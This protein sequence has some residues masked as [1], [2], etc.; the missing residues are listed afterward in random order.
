MVQTANIFIIIKWCKQLILIK[1]PKTIFSYAL[2]NR[3][4]NKAC[5]PEAPDSFPTSMLKNFV[6]HQLNYFLIF[7]NNI[8]KRKKKLPWLGSWR[9]VVTLQRCA[10]RPPPGNCWKFLRFLITRANYTEVYEVTEPMVVRVKRVRTLRNLILYFPLEFSLSLIFLVKKC[11]M[12]T[13]PVAAEPELRLRLRLAKAKAKGSF[14]PFAL[15]L[16]SQNGISV[17]SLIHGFRNETRFHQSCLFFY[18]LLPKVLFF[19]FLV[20]FT[21]GVLHVHKET[22]LP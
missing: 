7:Y 1:N 13:S 15:A 10:S 6:V 18:E 8:K 22:D 12:M 14:P 20:N 2:G 3:P 11:R 9:N 5:R 4:Q 16:C 21:K 19:F 17:Y